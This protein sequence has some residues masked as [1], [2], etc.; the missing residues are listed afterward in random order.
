MD[1]PDDEGD[2]GEHEA[3]GAQGAASEGG[4]GKPSG[5]KRGPKPAESDVVATLPHHGRPAFVK[6]DWV[7]DPGTGYV[8]TIASAYRSI[9]DRWEYCVLWHAKGE[10]LWHRASGW[11]DEQLR[12][13]SPRLDDG[14]D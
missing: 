11:T 1:M 5:R 12:P 10:G 8:G 2:V 4:G 14:A 7:L 3:H 9:R 13:C 6:N